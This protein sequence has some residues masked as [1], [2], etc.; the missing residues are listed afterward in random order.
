M[1]PSII[2]EIIDIMTLSPLIKTVQ[3]K[4]SF[5]MMYYNMNFEEKI[6]LLIDV[7]MH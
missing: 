3:H 6:I 2:L 7:T 5:P 1:K 4:I